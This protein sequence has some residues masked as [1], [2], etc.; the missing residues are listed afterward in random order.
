MQQT[1]HES[2]QLAKMQTK[3]LKTIPTMDICSKLLIVLIPFINIL[4]SGESNNN[5]QVALPLPTR[6]VLSVTS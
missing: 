6:H 5:S 1:Q 2:W 3:H 4:Q